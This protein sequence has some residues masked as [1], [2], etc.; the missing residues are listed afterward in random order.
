[1]ILRSPLI[2]LFSLF[3]LQVHSEMCQ[4]LRELN[5]MCRLW[6]EIWFRCVYTAGVWLR[7]CGDSVSRSVEKN[8]RLFPFSPNTLTSNRKV[9]QTLKT[10]QQSMNPVR[11]RSK[12]SGWTLTL[13]T[14]LLYDSHPLTD[15]SNPTILQL[16]LSRHTEIKQTAT[17]SIF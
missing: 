3:I 16:L 13:P 10:H 9:D 4:R 15:S 5:Y 14:V 12:P 7:F 6:N 11:L 17:N 2:R 1:M 8:T